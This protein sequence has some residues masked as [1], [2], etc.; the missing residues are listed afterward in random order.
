MEG[1][2]NA[3]D[4]T[5]AMENVD[6]AISSGVVVLFSKVRVRCRASPRLSLPPWVVKFTLQS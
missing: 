1:F 3:E 5:Q 6:K 4:G 2:A